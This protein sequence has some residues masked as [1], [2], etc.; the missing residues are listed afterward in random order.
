[1]TSL[2]V[3]NLTIPILLQRG[4]WGGGLPVW[5]H[6]ESVWGTKKKKNGSFFLISNSD[7]SPNNKHKQVLP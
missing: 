6:R 7:L 3:W 2:S 1:M 5:K 4:G